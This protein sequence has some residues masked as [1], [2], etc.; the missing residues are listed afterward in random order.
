MVSK[1]TMI[2]NPIKEAPATHRLRAP[3]FKKKGFYTLPLVLPNKCFRISGAIIQ[4]VIIRIM[5]IQFIF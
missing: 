2:G 1:F 3:K 5:D 4:M